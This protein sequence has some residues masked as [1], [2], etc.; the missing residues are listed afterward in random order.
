M[1][2]IRLLGTPQGKGRAR[3]VRSTGH[4][5]TPQATRSYEAALRYAAQAVMG[6]RSLLEGPLEVTV[7]AAFQIPKSFSKTKRLDA[8]SGALR[9]T[10]KPDADNLLKCID[11]L[12]GVVFA[13]DKQIVLA[14]IMKIYADKPDLTV[15][16]AEWGQA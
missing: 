8:L 15:Q 7:V 9:P 1:I 5:F 6:N 10:V 3:F 14:T 4:A 16:I 13:D 2:T 12:N 11:A